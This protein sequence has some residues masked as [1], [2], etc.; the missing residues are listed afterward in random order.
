MEAFVAYCANETRPDRSENSARP[1][2]GWALAERRL[3]QEGWSLTIPMSS[4]RSTLGGRGRHQAVRCGSGS[5]KD[6]I[7][8]DRVR[9]NLVDW[10]GRGDSRALCRCNSEAAADHR[11]L[12][13]GRRLRFPVAC[14]GQG[15]GGL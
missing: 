14:A 4:A 13:D 3:G 12:F 5:P 10:A 6:W 1:P 9:P 8:D 7:R 15:F 2:A 11:M